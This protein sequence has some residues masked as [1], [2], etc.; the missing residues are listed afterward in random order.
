[1]N[2]VI[3]SRAPPP[4]LL[5][6]CMDLSQLKQGVAVRAPVLPEPIELVVGSILGDMVKIVCAGKFTEC[7]A[8]PD[9]RFCGRVFRARNTLATRPRTGRDV[10]GT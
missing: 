2:N 8:R 10:P 4:R 6:S 1:M 9:R 3:L 5:G 7:A